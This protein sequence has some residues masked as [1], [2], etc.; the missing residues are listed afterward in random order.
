M[1]L[2]K[3]DDVSAADRA[4]CIDLVMDYADRLDAGDWDGF[5]ELFTDQVD[6]DY[7]AIGSLKARIPA[8]AWAERCKLLGY[9]DATRHRL[10]NMRYARSDDGATVTSAVDA[11]HFITAGGT[12]LYGDLVGD[13]RHELVRTGQGWRIAACRLTVAGYPAGKNAFDLVFA[14]ARAKQ[15]QEAVS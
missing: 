1:T 9:F 11:A 8:A 13:Y 12:T 5:R 3:A 10:S 4:A 2:D 6:I 15:N 14:S 7:A